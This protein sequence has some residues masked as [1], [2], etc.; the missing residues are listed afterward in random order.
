ME[1]WV[2]KTLDEMIDYYTQYQYDEDK[3]VC[4]IDMIR[5]EGDIVFKI[6]CFETLDRYYTRVFEDPDY[7]C[8]V[9]THTNKEVIY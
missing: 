8:D 1:F 4:P 9:E 7:Y 3:N 5:E 6:Y 2:N